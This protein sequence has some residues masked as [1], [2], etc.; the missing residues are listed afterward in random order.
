MPINYVSFATKNG[1]PSTLDLLSVCAS[2]LTPYY[3]GDLGIVRGATRAVILYVLHEHTQA[4]LSR[5]DD[6]SLRA[7]ALS[8]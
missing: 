4:V 6:S 8:G 2:C 1:L 3:I 7:S 5:L